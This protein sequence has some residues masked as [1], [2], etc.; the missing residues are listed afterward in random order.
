MHPLQDPLQHAIDVS[1]RL[2]VSASGG[3]DRCA[4]RQ[5]A[6]PWTI[7]HDR[8]LQPHLPIVAGLRSGGK[9]GQR[10]L[11]FPHPPRHLGRRDADA[12]ARIVRGRSL[13]QG[14]QV[15]S[16]I[17][18]R[19]RSAATGRTTTNYFSARSSDS[20]GDAAVS[21]NAGA[22]M[23]QVKRADRIEDYLFENGQGV[24]PAVIAEV[25]PR[26][27]RGLSTESSE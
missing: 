26:F 5:R 21:N 23:Q 8:Y 22:G 20:S 14:F 4:D 24:P 25:A 6:V 1:F 7:D 3:F 15:R 11:V 10:R 9:C 12:A 16:T 17:P 27:Y 2:G 19:P 13:Q 18:T